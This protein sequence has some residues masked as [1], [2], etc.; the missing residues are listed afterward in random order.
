MDNTIYKFFNKILYT[1]IDIPTPSDNNLIRNIL[2]NFK[3]LKWIMLLYITLKEDNDID[4]YILFFLF[5]QVSNLY[6]FVLV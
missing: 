4:G 2:N 6:N 5:F 1:Y 3:L